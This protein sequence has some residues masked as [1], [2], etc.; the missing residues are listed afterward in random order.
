MNN[1]VD[2]LW[3][4]LQTYYADF[5][6]L[7]P[8]LVLAIIAFSILFF[9]ANRSRDIVSAKLSDQMDDPLLA[10]F[11]AR[12]VKVAIVLFSLT[13]V[14]KIVGLADIASGLLTGA[15]V[16]AVVI[17]FAFKDI[18]EN[19]LAGIILAFNRP[20]RVGDTVELDGNKGRV[21]TLNMR[22]TQIKTFDGK[23]IYIPNA[24]VIKN[25]VINYTI[26]GFMRY[27]FNIGLD[28]GSDIDKAIDILRNTINNVEGILTGDKGPNVNIGALNSSSVNLT[29]QYWM[30]TFD[31]KFPGNVTRTKA[32]NK[33]LAALEEAGF[34]MPGDII[35]LKNYNDNEIKTGNNAPLGQAS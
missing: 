9:I 30:D 7:L 2:D 18:G 33:S 23:D 27:E 31:A 15:S 8:K 20:F 26:D 22:N 10:R 21:V 6:V 12:V 34:Y 1:F 13:V 35:E 11:L 25:P 28:Y 3:S 17:G 19:F 29:V 32:V 14:M 24:N 4:N 5:I 16:S